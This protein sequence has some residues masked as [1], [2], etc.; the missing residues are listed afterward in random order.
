MKY[1][2]QH[3]SGLPSSQDDPGSIA[4]RQFQREWVA[5]G[6]QRLP[7]DTPTDPP[8]TELRISPLSALASLVQ[9]PLERRKA[10]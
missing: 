9:M 4:A 3:S 1:A 7:T 2:M 8:R 5:A 6:Q 10:P